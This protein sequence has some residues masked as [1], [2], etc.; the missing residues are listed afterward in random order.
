MILLVIFLIGIFTFNLKTQDKSVE[1]KSNCLSAGCHKEMMNH[2]LT[3]PPTDEC[4]VCHISNG[5]EHPATSGK[6]F[7]LTKKVPDLCSDC[8][9][10][11]LKSKHNHTPY[12]NGECLSCH[13][14]HASDFNKLVKSNDKD[15]CITCHNKPMQLPDRQIPNIEQKLLA[16]NVH[17]P[18]QNGCIDCHLPHASNNSALILDEYSN[19]EYL[20]FE[21]TKFS[22]CFKCHD[23][24]LLTEALTTKSTDFRNGST[25]LH[26]LH[27][28]KEKS[29]NCNLCHD[30]HGS[31]NPKL[32]STSI[33]FG[34]WKF[35]P[36]FIKTATGGSCS[37]ACHKT[38]SYDINAKSIAKVIEEAKPAEEIKVIDSKISTTNISGKL[39]L[40]KALEDYENE[41]F[42]LRFK[43]A[44]GSFDT[45]ITVNND[46]SYSLEN[47]PQGELSVTI[48]DKTLKDLELPVIP[49]V[50]INT[51][52]TKKDTVISPTN[53]EIKLNKPVKPKVIVVP[54]KPKLFVLKSNESVG[55]E[56][57]VS[58]YLNRIIKYLKKHPKSKVQIFAYSDD[59]GTLKELQEKS[60]KMAKAIVDKLVSNG[61]SSSRIFA[62][63]KGPL[64]PISSNTTSKGRRANNRLEINIIK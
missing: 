57:E 40:P 42:E 7:N 18:V 64:S 28:K 6:E 38:Q 49:E 4:S 12:K 39:I 29:R 44:K 43:N 58:S 1:T 8:H 15:L 21:K 54:N 10:I 51:E 37:P 9:D 19:L 2:K 11:N 3:H 34:K 59:Q 26:Y 13:N 63:G 36:K 30:I 5:K 20:D 27:S 31:D 22:L 55:K 35:N 14:P 24:N 23:N 48:N 52:A 60:E 45:T 50:K 16:K 32:I 53:I 56:P 25:N 47:I 61:I 62:S 17:P 46:L 33:R 41:S